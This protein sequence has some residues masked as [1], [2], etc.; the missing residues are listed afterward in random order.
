M[1]YTM[2]QCVLQLD[3]LAFV[4]GLWTSLKTFCSVIACTS[5]D[6]PK[7]IFVFPVTYI[8]CRFFLSKE[9]QHCDSKNH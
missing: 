8:P 7:F 2:Y 5:L 9:Q 4:P 3:G 6:Y 1:S